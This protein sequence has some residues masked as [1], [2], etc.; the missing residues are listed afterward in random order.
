[1]NLFHAIGAV[2]DYIGFD[3]YSLSVAIS[4][5]SGD[6]AALVF[7]NCEHLLEPIGILINV[8]LERCSKVQVVA[9]SREAFKLRGEQIY[10]VPPLTFPSEAGLAAA[11]ASEAI[12]MFEECSRRSAHNFEIS[13]SNVSTI[14]RICE[15]LDGIPLAIEM[16]AAHVNLLTVE[17]IE[18]HLE[19]SFRLLV[20]STQSN[21]R[22]QTME[23]ALEWSVNTLTTEERLAFDQLSVF[24][25]GWTFEAA[26]SVLAFPD[27]YHTLDIMRRL[28]DKSLIVSVDLGRREG[29]SSRFTMLETVRQF[30]FSRLGQSSEV[31]RTRTLHLRYFLSLAERDRYGEDWVVRMSTEHYNL[32]AAYQWS[33]E[34]GNETLS[35][36]FIWAIWFYFIDF[37]FSATVYPWA[38]AALLNRSGIDLLAECRALTVTALHAYELGLF[39][40]T[41]SLTQESLELSKKLGD[42]QTHCITLHGRGIALRELGRVAEALAAFEEARDRA[43]NAGAKRSLG[44]A[45]EDLAETYRMQSKF[46]EAVT[47]YE[48]VLQ[49]ARVSANPSTVALI[50]CNLSLSLVGA[51]MYER[52]H[53]LLLESFDLV[54]SSRVDR[55]VPVLLDACS[56]LA[57]H[58]GE[59]SWAE[60]LGQKAF[61]LRRN[62]PW[63]R[64]SRPSPGVLTRSVSLPVNNSSKVVLVSRLAIESKVQ[65][66][67]RRL[68]VS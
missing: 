14:L 68:G 56:S 19:I 9:T 65:D 63:A 24:S 62:T 39:E 13:E 15:R 29:V 44:Q 20:N 67:L 4:A 2:F 66:W 50:L 38:K 35:L 57:R 54:I 64:L 23:T 34:L 46:R 52:V 1:M 27:D 60:E 33:V 45:L 11:R 25:A 21:P 51:G 53:S 31:D 43:S 47:A 6:G 49:L 22:H 28:L 59:K 37:G 42:R 26:C 41:L 17:E 18:A 5:R 55:L 30:A 8:I 12:R 58:L 7:D 3:D 16:A 40:E 32:I 36:R 61:E 48:E 10:I